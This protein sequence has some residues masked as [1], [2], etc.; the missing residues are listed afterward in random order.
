MRVSGAPVD[1]EAIYDCPEMSDASIPVGTYPI[2]VSRGTI[3]SDDV[4]LRDGV[5]TV[6]PVSIKVTAKSYTRNVGEPN[7]DFEVS[8]ARFRNRE[9]AS[10]LTKQPV[11]SC[12]ATVDSPAGVYPITVSGA[13]AQNYVFTYVDGTLTIVDPTGIDAP[14]SG[15]QPAV[16]YDLQGRRTT[17]PRKGLYIQNGVKVVIK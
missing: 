10:V 2:A 3:A 8:Y 14:R 7:P 9:N 16:L 17:K 6:E 13:E 5:L 15:K 4:E 12:E 11:I 1:G